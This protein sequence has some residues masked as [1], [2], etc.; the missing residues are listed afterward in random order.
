MSWRHAI[1]GFLSAG[2]I[3]EIAGMASILLATLD[4]ETVGL[5][6]LVPIHLVPSVVLYLT[7]C[8]IARWERW[9]TWGFFLP[10]AGFEV[11]FV[12]VWLSGGEG[13][14]FA[15]YMAIVLIASGTAAYLTLVCF[16]GC[17]DRLT[18]RS[19]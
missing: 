4:V 7:C 13:S 17:I 2:L 15:F 10:F 5:G 9:S 19:T 3:A 16:R 11:W 8:S 14:G 18:R 6:L 12:A 1:L